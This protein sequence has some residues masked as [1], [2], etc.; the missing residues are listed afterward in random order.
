MAIRKIRKNMK[1]PITVFVVA[2]IATILFTVVQGL[3][4]YKSTQRHALIING[5]KVDTFAIEREF[6]RGIDSYRRTYGDTLD[7]EELKVILFDRLVQKELLVQ[8][9][10][11][12]EKD[13]DRREEAARSH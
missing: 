8:S 3:R 1:G 7:A 6:S 13:H 4:D 11:D 12:V 5:Q 9:A 10:K 2:F